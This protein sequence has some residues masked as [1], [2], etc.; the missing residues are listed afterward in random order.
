MN[1]SFVDRLY[2][3]L[4]LSE[5]IFFDNPPIIVEDFGSFKL[6]L[7]N[8]NLIVQMIAEYKTE[9]DARNF[10]EPYL[11]VWELD[12]LIE[13]GRKEFQFEFVNSIIVDKNPPPSDGSKIIET[14]VGE[15]L[16]LTDHITVHIT[17]KNYPRPP[18]TLLYS[19]DVESLS[20]RYEG[21]L[22]GKEPILSMAYFCLSLIQ[23]KIN[24]RKE[25]ARI[26]NIDIAVLDKLGELTSERGNKAE[27]RKLDKTSTLIPLRDAES[28]WI[29]QT[30]KALIRRKSEY[31]FNPTAIF[32]LID[33]SS[34]PVL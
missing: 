20:K 18:H 11:R 31:D 21:Y 14:Q 8:N 32:P 29:L 6:E 28:S 25:A 5:E 26:Y 12:N 9:N 13:R 23:S 10:V 17:R 2:Y 33:F 1:K 3:T 34:L 15:L 16:I 4:K 30:I 7:K 19:P 22:D 27:A 24:G